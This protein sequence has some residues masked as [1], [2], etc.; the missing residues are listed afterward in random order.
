MLNEKILNHNGTKNMAGEMYNF[1]LD[2]HIGK[3]ESEPWEDG[4]GLDEPRIKLL[5][6]GKTRNSNLYN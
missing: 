4:V 6:P 3:G 1:R 5:I 2:L